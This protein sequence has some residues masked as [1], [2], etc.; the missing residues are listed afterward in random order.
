MSVET[1]VERIASQR[2]VLEPL[3]EEHAPAMFLLLDDVELYRH[4][5]FAPPPSLYHLREVYRRLEARHS[6]DGTEEWLNWVILPHGGAP[7]GFVQ[8]TVRPDGA[9]YIAYTL[10]RR[11][12]G[13]GFAAEA[14]RA[15]LEHLA[16]VHDVR[17]FV[18]TVEKDNERSIRLLDRLGFHAAT[19]EE[20]QGHELSPTELL[21]VRR[22]SSGVNP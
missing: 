20:L 3:L 19:A 8:A 14:T 7:M 22:P 13:H 10:G 15:M 4:L 1:E 9:A 11:H 18:A 17:C 6:P 16:E 2:L 12:W 21:Y 5:D